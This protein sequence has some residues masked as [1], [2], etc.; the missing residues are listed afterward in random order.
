MQRKDMEVSLQGH[1]T[2]T[3][4]WIRTK[5]ATTCKANVHNKTIE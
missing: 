4:T 2:L 5:W 3:W 1:T